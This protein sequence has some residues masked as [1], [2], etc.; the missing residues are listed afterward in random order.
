MAGV[1]PHLAVAVPTGES[2]DEIPADSEDEEEVPPEVLER[3]QRIGLVSWTGSIRA[4]DTGHDQRD[5]ED[6]NDI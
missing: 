1:R 5:H 3:D 6:K 4:D 2:T